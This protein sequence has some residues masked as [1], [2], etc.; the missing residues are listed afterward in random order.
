MQKHCHVLQVKSENLS[1]KLFS[2]KSKVKEFICISATLKLVSRV[3][4]W[5]Y[6]QTFLL[7]KDQGKGGDTR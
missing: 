5:F 6:E 1:L 7:K 4:S 2:Y 3:E